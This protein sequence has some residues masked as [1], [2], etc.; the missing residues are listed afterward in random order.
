VIEPRA[1]PE[2]IEVREEEAAMGKKKIRRKRGFDH[3]EKP[4]GDR[5]SRK[6]QRCQKENLPHYPP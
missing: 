1:R 6:V 3:L 2:E 4:S 5:P